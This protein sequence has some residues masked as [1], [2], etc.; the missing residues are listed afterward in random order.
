MNASPTPIPKRFAT[1]LAVSI[2][3]ALLFAPVFYRVSLEY[4]YLVHAGLA[5]TMLASG[6]PITPHFL[7]QLLTIGCRCLLPVS[8]ET[9]QFLVV[10]AALT[11]TAFLLFVRLRQTSGS[12]GT[13]ALL[14]PVLLL[15]APVPLLA[16]FDESLY[17]GYIGINVYHNP[18]I[19]LLK[20]LALLSFGY[21][22]AALDGTDNSGFRSLAAVTL[23]TVAA[24]VAKPSFTICLLPALVLVILSNRNVRQRASWSILAGGFF[25][26]AIVVLAAQFWMTYSDTQAP[27]VYAGKS[28]VVF[29]PLAVMHSYS[30]W[31]FPKLILS[32]LFPLTLLICNARSVLRDTGLLLAWSSF[33]AGAAYT[34]LLA[35]AGPRMPQ[36][37]FT[38]SAQ[39]TLFLLFVC[40][41][42]FLWRHAPTRPLRGRRICTVLLVLHALSG[43]L[44][45]VTECIQSQKFW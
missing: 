16:L 30:S 17:L 28:A 13:A 34:Y 38:W 23:T 15:A 35:E 7:L 40:S 14:T 36:G 2:G 31:L 18:T 20:P 24:L 21:A 42:T 22:V 32:L 26:P 1:P 10:M 4:D 39:I 6:R 44:F 19:V 29:A 33:L 41:A 25:T 8:M 3:V 37:N 45:Y 9:A 11:A 27:G 43:V 5:R 12:S